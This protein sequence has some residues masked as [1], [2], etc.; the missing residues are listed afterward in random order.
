[1]PQLVWVPSGGEHQSHAVLRESY[2]RGH[3]WNSKVG[4]YKPSV[5]IALI[6]E[7]VFLLPMVVQNNEVSNIQL[8]F[9]NYFSD[10]AAEVVAS[11][12][13]LNQSANFLHLDPIGFIVLQKH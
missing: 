8:F 7:V 1:M 3:S 12:G 11:T 6:L 5:A 13:N 2:Q 4:T 10:M 9:V